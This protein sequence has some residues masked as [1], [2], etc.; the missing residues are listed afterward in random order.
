MAQL[1]GAPSH[2]LKV[3]HIDPP[4]QHTPGLRVRSLVR[5]RTRDNRSMFLSLPSLLPKISRHVLERGRKTTVLEQL[6]IHWPKSDLTPKGKK[7]FFTWFPRPGIAWLQPTP[8]RLV[9]FLVTSLGRSSLGPN[10]PFASSR[11]RRPRLHRPFTC[12]IRAVSRVD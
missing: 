7:M 8:A 5:V 1:V 3:R 10:R 2:K 12:F 11:M 9:S 6:D 4:S